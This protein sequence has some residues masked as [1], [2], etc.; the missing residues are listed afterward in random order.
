MFEATS[1][2]KYSGVRSNIRRDKFRCSKQ[3]QTGNIQVFE[4]TSDEKYSGVRSNIRRDKY[5]GV[6]SNIRR[7]IF[8]CL[9]QHQ[10]GNTWVFEATSNT[11]PRRMADLSQRSKGT[12]P[13]LTCST[14]PFVPFFFCFVHT[15]HIQEGYKLKTHAH[16]HTH[17][18]SFHFPRC[19]KDQIG[20][21]QK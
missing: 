16:A 15:L 6:R 8:R 11:I 10:T 1:D 21:L 9:K 20:G 18:T 4:A 17:G 2:G 19:R 14:V 7:E 3:H 13:P 5:S 12:T